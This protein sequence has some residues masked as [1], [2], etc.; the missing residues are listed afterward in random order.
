MDASWPRAAAVPL[1]PEG[2]L[3][4]GKQR[5]LARELV[6]VHILADGLLPFQPDAPQRDTAGSQIDVD[7]N[8]DVP[9]CTAVVGGVIHRADGR[10]RVL[11]RAPYPALV[12]V[13]AAQRNRHAVQHGVGDPH[14]CLPLRAQRK[15]R[16]VAILE[17]RGAG[18]LQP[19]LRA[20]EPRRP[21]ERGLDVPGAAADLHAVVHV[22]QILLHHRAKAQIHLA[23]GCAQADSEQHPA[24]V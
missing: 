24:S 4:A 5:T 2:A 8:A 12:A 3:P 15:S 20:S 17:M 9:V 23:G 16:V 14:I 22:A 1:R 21:G 7:T 6:A 13:R 18:E 19:P 10:E 11:H